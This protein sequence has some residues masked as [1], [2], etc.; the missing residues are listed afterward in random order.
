MHAPVE[1]TPIAGA[2]RGAPCDTRACDT[3]V[4]HDEDP[5]TQVVIGHFASLHVG[6]VIE[7]I[8]AGWPFQDTIPTVGELARLAGRLFAT[9]VRAA[10]TAV[11]VLLVTLIVLA[12][13]AAA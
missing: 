4:I 5:P 13:H 7:V 6:E 11:A 1:E 2:E 8:R 10:G 9:P 3:R 12:A